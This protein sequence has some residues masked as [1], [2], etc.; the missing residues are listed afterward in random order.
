ME[1]VY[2]FGWRSHTAI[3][4]TGSPPGR[5]CPCRHAE[6]HAAVIELALSILRNRF[7]NDVGAEGFLKDGPVAVAK[8]ELGEGGGGAS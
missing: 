8:F 2:L 7:A 6:K 1:R 5:P 3:F 4:G